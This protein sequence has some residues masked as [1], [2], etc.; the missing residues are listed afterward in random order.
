MDSAKKPG[1]YPQD[2]LPP[3][4]MRYWDGNAWTERVTGGGKPGNQTM[5]TVIAVLV[6][7][8]AVAFGLLNFLTQMG[9]T[10]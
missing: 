10:R 4:Q 2:G 1:W 8:A 6:I 3:G 5:W 9:R 7:L